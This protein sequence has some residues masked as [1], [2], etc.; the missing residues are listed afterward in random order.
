DQDKI[1]QQQ[2]TCREAEQERQWKQ[3]QAL[4]HAQ[5]QQQQQSIH[6]QRVQA[7]ARVHRQ[8][9]AD[10]VPFSPDQTVSPLT[11]QLQ[12][13]TSQDPNV[14]APLASPSPGSRTPFPAPQVK[15]SRIHAPQSPGSTGPFSHPSLPPPPP[16]PPP[17]GGRQE[18][19]VP[20]RPTTLTLPRGAPTAVVRQSVTTPEQFAAARLPFPAGSQPQSPFSPQPPQSPHEQ[21]FPQSPVS[22]ITPTTPQ[23]STPQTDPFQRPPSENSNTDPYGQPPQTP[24]PQFIAS[25]HQS[26]S[27]TQRSPVY[28]TAPRPAADPY[29]Q[30]P[31]TPRPQFN[32]PQT[33]PVQQVVYAR[34][35]PQ[36]QQA[37]QDPYAAQP[38]TPRPVQSDPFVQIATSRPQDPY[39]TQPPTPRPQSVDPYAQQPATP[40][41]RVEGEVFSQQQP[42]Q[43]PEVTRQLRDLLQ[44]QQ[45]TKKLEQETVVQGQPRLWT[46]Q[47]EGQQA[48]QDSGLHPAIQQQAAQQ[49]QQQQQ[50]Q[51]AV[52]FDSSPGAQPTPTSPHPVSA[53]NSDGTFRQPLPPALVRPRLPSQT[54]VVIRTSA[55]GVRHPL[56][57]IETRLQGVDPRTRLLLQ[58]QRTIGNV[59]GY[60][61]HIVHRL[62]GPRNPLD[63]YDH[64]VQQ[65]QLGFAQDGSG[66]QGV[67]APN[68]TVLATQRLVRPASAIEG[69]HPGA[70]GVQMRLTRVA[71]KPG[72]PL[73][74]ATAQRIAVNQPGPGQMTL[75][76]PA[77]SSV[78][79]MSAQQSLASASSVQQVTTV[80]A[81]PGDSQE[82]P[83]SVTAELEKLEQDGG[84]VEVEGVG[85]I[86][87]ELG[88]D[89]ELLAMGNDFNILEYADPELDSVTGGE[90][91]NILDENLDLEEEESSKEE[92]KGEKKELPVK[93][94]ENAGEGTP[95]SSIKD[96]A[97]GPA[98]PPST[99]ETDPTLRASPAAPQPT[100]TPQPVVQQVI[101]PQAQEMQTSQPTPPIAQKPTLGRP[102]VAG[103]MVSPD[104]GVAVSF[105]NTFPSAASS[106]A[107]VPSAA[108]HLQRIPPGHLQGEFKLYFIFK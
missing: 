68:A 9:S 45:F 94:R 77:V 6:E 24:R 71:T 54:N 22:S 101:Q 34:A 103:R 5:V 70:L 37:Q 95:S 3:L 2:K 62:A 74:P 50:Q 93:D 47:A 46:P 33:R 97:S 72:H 87:A 75:P 108:G 8:M 41:P 14:L 39:A 98:A 63:P 65:R 52:H 106:P 27:V 91:T 43:G 59:Q 57:G 78:V 29:A 26:P 38:P 83:E 35:Q 44:R 19:L 12:V 17:P 48:A 40:R 102:V 42:Q 92:H 105:Q 85:A 81:S 31:S 1:L 104:G 79:G 80:T 30:A 10:G 99:G 89:K 11:T 13:S 25:G 56:Q 53:T 90:K 36:S 66:T 100:T 61:A 55:V 67:L 16:L 86:L 64:L 18:M 15:V 84:M 51:T 96:D 4:R 7:M 20:T 28:V 73:D 88:D 21:Q 69:G 107:V 32:A 58:Q 82:I 49:V 76:A 60:P 23:A